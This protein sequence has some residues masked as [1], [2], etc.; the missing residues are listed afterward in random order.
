VRGA[1][2]A[3]RAQYRGDSV[4]RL[5]AKSAYIEDSEPERKDAPD[6]VGRVSSL[7]AP[8]LVRR[9][10]CGPV[11]FHAEPVFLVEIVTVHGYAAAR[12]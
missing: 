12:H 5:A 7:I 4:G 9:M 1:W 11:K 3:A 2:P 6:R 10:C 8:L